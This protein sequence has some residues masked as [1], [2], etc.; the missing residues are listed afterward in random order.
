MKI[1]D[2]L[3]VIDK[4]RVVG[5]GKHRKLLEENRYY[6]RLFKEKI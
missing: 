2:K 6:K 1:A 5:I 4:G 3:I